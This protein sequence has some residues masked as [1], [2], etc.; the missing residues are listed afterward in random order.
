LTLLALL[1]AAAFA[2]QKGTFT[3]TR[4][5]KKYK[6]V[7]IGKQT[8]MAENMNYVDK[9]D[10][11]VDSKCYDNKPANCAKYGRLYNWE[12]AMVACPK[13]WHLPTRAE[14]DSLEAF[15][16]DKDTAENKHETAENKL[17]AKSGWDKNGD[18]SGNGTDK[19]G[20]SALPGG[21]GSFNGDFALAGKGGRWWVT[22]ELEGYYRRMNSNFEN[23]PWRSTS[24]SYLFSVRCLQG[25][26]NLEE[27]S[28]ETKSII[29]SIPANK[30]ARTEAAA[31][32]KAD[33]LAKAK[34][35]A[36]VAAKAKADSLAK[37]KAEAA[38]KAK[39]DKY[40]KTNG[41]T[42][43]DSRD[44]RTYKTIKIGTQVWMAENLDYADKDSKCHGDC[45]KYGRLYNWA[46]AIN[47]CPADWHLPTKDEWTTLINATGKESSAGK[48]LKSISGWNST[49]ST[50]NGT[51]EYGFTA[52]PG[53]TYIGTSI[54][55]VENGGNWWSS[56]EHDAN[57][58]NRI[59]LVYYESKV[60]I[61]GLNTPKTDFYSVRCLK[62][63]GEPIKVTQPPAPQP[64]PQQPAAKP[65]AQPQP[66]PKQQVATE[67]CNVTF[68][69]KACVSVPKNSCK[70]MGGKVVDKCP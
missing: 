35:E 29:A 23:I 30:K 65:A 4:D 1:C 69:K 18:N 50:G 2:Q 10:T 55:G 20:F 41:G 56:T 11:D 6:T 62:G 45:T 54:R 21:R 52:L 12:T 9:N 17:K 61:D 37:A 60:T 28:M 51:D 27:F 39:S 68:P 33:S 7:K 40:I 8:W 53:G 24:G 67:N 32:A 46:T 22:S 43:I 44:K 26:L 66:Q 48:Y 19:F 16:I 58:A 59:T 47:I 42:F 3:D 15:V 57:K 34:V 25:E 14:L 31:K 13:G 70:L 49:D 38:I 36:E 64:A 63:K 5:K